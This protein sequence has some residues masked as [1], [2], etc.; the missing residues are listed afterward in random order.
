MHVGMRAVQTGRRIALRIACAAVAGF[1][2]SAASAYPLVMMPDSTNNRI[3][4]F[5]PFDGSLVNADVFALAGGTPVQAIQ[6][7][8]EIWVSE[9]VGDRIS[10]WDFGGGSLGAITGAMDNVRGLSLINNTV[11]VANDGTANGAPGAALRMFDTNGGDLGFFSTPSSSPFYI[12][13]YRNSL[14][15]A[16]DAGNDDI[17]RYSYTG[18]S[19]GTFHN[20]T[21][22]NFA[23]QMVFAH[24]ENILVAGFSSNYVARLDAD[25]GAIISTFPASGARGVFQLENGNILWSNSAGVHV[26]DVNTGAS[27]QVYAGGGRFFSLLIP[28]PSTLALLSLSGVAVL[29]RRRG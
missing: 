19:L 12:M 29:L 5:D 14:L 4:H 1:A 13:D 11:Y 8:K 20:S 28:E 6:V 26:Y 23:E 22:L 15:V 16:S 9:Q 27:T 25:N 21:S 3:V 2:V 7:G 24:D 18:T 10:R 17:H